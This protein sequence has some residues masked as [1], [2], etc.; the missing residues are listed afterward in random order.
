MV[1]HTFTFQRA[2]F[3]AQA[4]PLLGWVPWVHVCEYPMCYPMIPEVAD[5]Y[6]LW[7]IGDPAPCL[8]S[9]LLG[10]AG[11]TARGF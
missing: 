8:N 1:N 6:M 7:I 10:V 11:S 2:I 3:F 5:V 4:G 9:Q